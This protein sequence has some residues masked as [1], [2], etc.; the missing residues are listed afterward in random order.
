MFWGFMLQ[1]NLILTGTGVPA[2][3]F[4]YECIYLIL[5]NVFLENFQSPYK[6]RICVIK[7]LVGRR[8]RGN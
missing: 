5:K 6:H 8:L 2:C 1:P 4:M 3:L 7:G